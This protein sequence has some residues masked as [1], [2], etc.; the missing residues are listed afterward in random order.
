M[1]G[2]RKGPFGGFGILGGEYVGGGG[3]Q[4][5]LGVRKR[6]DAGKWGVERM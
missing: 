1:V 6:G 2:G 3:C 4:E 5:G